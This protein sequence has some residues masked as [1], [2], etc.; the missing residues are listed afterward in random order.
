MFE[1]LRYFSLT[2][3]VAILSVTVVLVVF[4]R[5]NAVSDLVGI[6][7]HQNVA[8]GRSFAN[9]I[10]PRFSAYVTGVSGLDGDALRA[11]PETRQIQEA[12][13][14]IA[15]GL[16]VL[17]VKIYNLDGLTVFSSEASQIGADKSNNPGFF[18]AARD[19]R[20]A[21][22][23]VHKDRFSAFSGEVTD[24]HFVESYLPIRRGDGP[25]EGVFEL[26]SDVT[27]LI[28]KIEHFTDTLAVG[29]VL[30]FG[31]LYGVLF[32][33]VRHGDRIIKRQYTDVLRAEQALQDVNERL[34]RRVELRTSKLTQEITE[35]KRAE[36]ALR[37][38]DTRLH[39]V[40]TELLNVSRQSAL[41]ELS[42]ALAH[43]LNQPLAAIMNYVEAS[44]RMIKKGGGNVSENAYQMMD[45]ALH[46]ANRA[47]AIIRGLRD[48]VETG[49]AAHAES[50]INKVVEEASAL[51][52]IG[53]PR[54]DIL[55]DMKFGANLPPVIINEI[56]IQQVVMNL[57]RN[58]A[59]AMAASEKRNLTIRTA[60]DREDAVEIAIGDTGPGL[61]EEVEDRLFQPFV[62]TKAGGMGIGLSISQ[63]I[64]AAH[65]GRLWATPNPDGGTVF[66][67]TLPLAPNGAEYNDE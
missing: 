28:G 34:E 29:L 9:T 18:A 24:R 45:K 15:A 49:E 42:S 41:G 50:D 25:T 62:S 31:L 3:A 20:P 13:K 1:L 48:M 52:L 12:L 2:S 61:A 39:E 59:E 26:Y 46:Q 37:A 35:R 67:F 57:V 23:L 4:Y 43:E 58:G 11:R 33:I 40:Q 55:V 8:L 65:G 22:K 38:R 60:L 14:K 66:H 5:N 64:V 44:R 10:W 54:K 51:G 47:G 6:A 56:Q 17:K 19:G 7:E 16:P 30:V 21:S 53:A 36:V 63:S 27:P 32:L